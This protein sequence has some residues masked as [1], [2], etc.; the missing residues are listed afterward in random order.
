MLLSTRKFWIGIIPRPPHHAGEQGTGNREQR[1]FVFHVPCYLFLPSSF[2]LLA[3]GKDGDGAAVDQHL[4]DRQEL[5][6]KQDEDAG[7][8]QQGEDEE[9]RAVDDVAG[10]DDTESAEDGERRHEVEDDLFVAHGA[11]IASTTTLGLLLS[12]LFLRR[13]L[14]LARPFG[15][16]PAWV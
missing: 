13:G 3:T 9:Q 1:G 16:A 10:E 5:G 14:F 15:F 7:D 6:R 8:G 12:G 2:A 11:T 4:D